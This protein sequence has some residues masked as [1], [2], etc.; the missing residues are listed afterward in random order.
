MQNSEFS[1]KYKEI[2]QPLKNDFQLLDKSFEN[3]FS[4]LTTPEEKNEII[5]ILKDFFS[6]KGKRI[7]SALIF[8]ITRALGKNVDDFCLNIAIAT[9]LIHNATLIHD[10][11]IDCA[12]IRRGKQTLN[13]EHDS[14]L[15]VLA[16]D[17]LLTEAIN[18]LSTIN[19]DNKG[20]QIRKI[21]TDC[22]SSLVKGELKQYFNRFKLLKIEDYIEK[23]QAKTGKL[24]EASIVV[25]YL[26]NDENNCKNIEKIKNFA[27]NFGIMFQIK[28][29]LDNLCYPEKI[30]EDI[31]NGDYSAPIIFWAQEKKLKNDTLPSPE[32]IQKQLNQSEAIEKTKALLNYYSNKAIENISFLEDNL[33]K[34]TIIELCK[35]FVQ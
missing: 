20:E 28:N 32:L 1:K 5:L 3:Y 18:I 11:I 8:L 16:G 31:N 4:G 34:Q 30:S 27:L 14:K 22:L 25:T 13:F 9:E 2:I 24:F 29:D 10:D 15:A 19:E 21:Y 26:R 7:R 23:S 35:L 17:Y 33:Y 12:S 6:K